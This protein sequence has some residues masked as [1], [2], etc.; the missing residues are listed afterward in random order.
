MSTVH[1]SLEQ[2]I[3]EI[4]ME[5]LNASWSQALRHASDLVEATASLLST[6]S[7]H[8]LGHLVM[9]LIPQRDPPRVRPAVRRTCAR[10]RLVGAA[11]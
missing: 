8:L 11:V 5:A 1:A 3:D 4:G 2:A 6:Q 9:A 10:R 7:S